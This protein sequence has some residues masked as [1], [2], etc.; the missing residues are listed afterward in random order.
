MM[1]TIA[2]NIV[3]SA[4]LLF[5]ASALKAQQNG[6]GPHGGRLKTAGSY[7]IELLGCDN[8]LEIYLFDSDT[9]A[10][11]N[12]DIEGT[13]EFFYSAQATLVSPL[14]HYGMDGFT[15]KIPINTFLYSK[16]SLTVKGTFIVTEKF[17]NECIMNAGKN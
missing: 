2:K 17:D 13:V 3:M 14:V 16:P 1:K 8:Y 15:A 12:N 9:N 5:F 11:N 7:K 6:L 10:I 4:G